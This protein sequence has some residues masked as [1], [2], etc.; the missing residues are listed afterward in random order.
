MTPL[1]QRRIEDMKLRGYAAR[2]QEAYVAAVR[3]LA[4]HYRKSP[5]EITEEELRQYFLYLK[6]G[7]KLAR[8][9]IT[10]ALCGIKVLFEQ[11]LQ[12]QWHLFEIVRPPREKKLP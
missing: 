1:R 9:S 8:N 11:S 10:I 4:E 6:D 12:R 2:T 5:G 3:Q 7:K